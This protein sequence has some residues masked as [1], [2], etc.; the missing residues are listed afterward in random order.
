[1]LSNMQVLRYGLFWASTDQNYDPCYIYFLRTLTYFVRVNQLNSTDYTIKNT[2]MT[3][4]INKLYVIISYFLCC[5]RQTKYNKTIHIVY[6]SFEMHGNYARN[7]PRAVHSSENN[8][9]VNGGKTIT[10]LLLPGLIPDVQ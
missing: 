4:H 10:L 6:S 1:M 5:P 3:H 2:E 7:K 9:R 8:V